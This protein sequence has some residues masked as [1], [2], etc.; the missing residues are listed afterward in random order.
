MVAPRKSL[1]D[2]AYEKIKNNILNLTYAPGMTLTE[3]MLT[4][5]LGMS[6]NPDCTQNVAVRRT[7]CDGLL[8]IHACKRDQLPSRH[9]NLSDS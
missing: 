4:Q 9:R 2:Q 1:A 5:E 8:Q 3:S 6:R 7:D